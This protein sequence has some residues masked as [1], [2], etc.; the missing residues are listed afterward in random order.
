MNAPAPRRHR[1]AQITSAGVPIA[2]LCSGCTPALN[3]WRDPVSGVAFIRTGTTNLA[4]I[5]ATNITCT[6][7]VVHLLDTVLVPSNQGIP[8]MDVVATAVAAN[9]TA[10]ANALTAANLVSALSIATN[11]TGIFTV[12]APTNAAFAGVPTAVTSNL[13]ALT[14]VLTTHVITGRVY[15]GNLPLNT[16]LTVTTLSGAPI[17]ILRTSAGVT[18]YSAQSTATVAV[19][20]VDSSN[21]VVHVIN[22]VLIPAGV[23]TSTSGATAA[24]ALSFAAA[25]LAVVSA[26][27]L[28]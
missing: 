24:T 26:A 2:P 11:P 14:A 6:N 3:A 22:N 17:T 1:F 12:F 28:L 4:T 9:L 10:L 27:V 7:G 20:D 19:A 25:L 13:T 23:R 21:A 16:N 18:I 15:S 5:T 8:T